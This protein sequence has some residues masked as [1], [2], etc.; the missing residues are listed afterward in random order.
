MVAGWI[1]CETMRALLYWLKILRYS[2]NDFV[3]GVSEIQAQ[4]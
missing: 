4:Q 3:A 2:D 1:L